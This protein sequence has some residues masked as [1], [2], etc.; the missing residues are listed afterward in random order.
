M[1]DW[2]DEIADG[3]VR[4]DY[5]Y[6][7]NCQVYASVDE[8]AATLR[9]AKADGVMHAAEIFESRQGPSI[10]ALDGIKSQFYRYL[11]AE[12]DKIEHPSEPSSEQKPAVRIE[13]S[14][15]K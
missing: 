5:D 4:E 2:A 7:D 11:K 13:S 3:L 6:D 8:I 9:K 15:T 14:E 10:L 12:A 1:T